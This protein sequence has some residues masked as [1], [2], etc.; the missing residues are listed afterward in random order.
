MQSNALNESP[1]ETYIIGNGG[2]VS[3]LDNEKDAKDNPLYVYQYQVM[4]H[5][6]NKLSARV[7]RKNPHLHQGLL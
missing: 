6:V 3:I 1:N 2:N 4:M 5:A 7:R